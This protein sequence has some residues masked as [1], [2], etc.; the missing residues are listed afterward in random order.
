MLKT[1]IKNI[2]IFLLSPRSFKL[3]L[4]T[5][6]FPFGPRSPEF[7]DCFGADVDWSL[8]DCFDD[9]EKRDALD[10]HLGVSL[11]AAPWRVG[12]GE[13]RIK[14]PVERNMIAL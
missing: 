14:R 9:V 5:E 6:G 1:T 4:P 8:S 13:S 11:D 3:K 12:E 2:F 10:W 7:G